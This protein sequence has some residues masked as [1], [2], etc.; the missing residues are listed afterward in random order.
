MEERDF[1][2][3]FVRAPTS[4]KLAVRRM[5]LAKSAHAEPKPART[6]WSG[7]IGHNAVSRAARVERKPGHVIASKT[8]Q[9]VKKTSLKTQL[10]L[11]NHKGCRVN[12]TPPI[13]ENLLPET[14]VF[15][16]FNQLQLIL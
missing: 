15:H 12:S 16:L 4:I 8:R 1:K 11:E 6:G 10:K 13:D 5:T 3:A 7:L 9:V 14:A 2:T